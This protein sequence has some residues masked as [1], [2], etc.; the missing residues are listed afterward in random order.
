MKSWHITFIVPG[1]QV[2]VVLPNKF[3]HF[4]A[5]LNVKSKTDAIDAKLL[6]RFGVEREHRPWNPAELVI[7]RMRDFSRYRVQLQ[8]QK[9][10]ITNILHSKD[11]AHGVPAD[12]KKSSKK[13]IAVLEKEIAILSKEMEK[14]VKSDP[15]IEAKVNKLR[16]IPGCGIT[17]VAAIVAET[18]GFK[19]FKSAK[20]LTSY[21]GYD[22]VHN[23]SG[24]SVLSKTRIS[25]KGNRYMRHHMHMPALSASKHIPEFKALKERIKAKTGIPM[26]AQVAVQRKLLILMYTLWKND[27][28]YEKD[29]HQK[30]VAR[31]NA[32]ATQDSAL[33]QL[34]LEV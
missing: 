27:L 16:T 23:E 19:E 4:A 2:H 18:N 31:N 29:Y 20:Q 6:A 11:Y 3:K 22:I 30:K 12:I 5:S 25:K 32:Q 21:A 34:P 1:K 33:Q 28:V 17:T 13:V 10:A 14:V 9:T 7:K 15:E 24:T 26:K 8:E